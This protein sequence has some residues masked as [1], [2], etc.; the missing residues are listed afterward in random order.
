MLL[1]L[2]SIT[3]TKRRMSKKQGA[4]YLFPSSRMSIL[5]AQEPHNPVFLHEGEVKAIRPALENMRE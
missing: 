3:K 1:L 4:V 5:G 2:L